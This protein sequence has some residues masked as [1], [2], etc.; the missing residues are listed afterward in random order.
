MSSNTLNIDNLTIHMAAGWQGDPVF[1]ARKISEQIQLQAKELN[2]AKQ[3][4]ISL[5]GQFNSNPKQLAEQFKRQLLN[6]NRSA[7]RGKIS[8]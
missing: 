1:L 5:Q 4:S 6:H 7:S 2:S 8:D 3:I